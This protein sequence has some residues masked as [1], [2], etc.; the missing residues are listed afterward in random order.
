MKN[1]AIMSLENIYIFLS[2]IVCKQHSA[3]RATALVND[4]FDEEDHRQRPW[5]KS[6]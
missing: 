1:E 4:M 6:Q 5:G 2:P 3:P